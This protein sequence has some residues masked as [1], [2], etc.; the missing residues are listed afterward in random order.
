MA[1]VELV[2]TIFG[3]ASGA[4]MFL[5]ALRAQEQAG[6][7][8]LLDA[9]VVSKNS[10]GDVEIMET[11]D[12]QGTRG[13][14]LGAAGGAVLGLLAGPVGALIGMVAGAATGGAAAETI[15]TGV[16][17]HIVDD[18]VIHLKPGM[19]AFLALIEAPWLDRVQNAAL[20]QQNITQVKFWHH[21]ISDKAA[22]VLKDKAKH[23]PKHGD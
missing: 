2:I 4:D 11:E 13:A 23:K 22:E 18:F 3:A 10:T 17:D 7:L 9:V 19:S 1:D 12:M 16:P 6:D 15:D 20:A 5:D 21:T 14:L 8:F